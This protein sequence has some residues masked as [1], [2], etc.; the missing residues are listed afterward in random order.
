VDRFREVELTFASPPALPARLPET[1]MQ[2]NSS[3]AVVR[4]VE[5]RFDAE[6]TTAEILQ[7]FGETRG[8]AFAPMTLRSIFLTMAKDGTKLRAGR[9]DS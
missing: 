5:S 8:S 3:A 7:V 2:M 4:F 6:K 1:W 9:S